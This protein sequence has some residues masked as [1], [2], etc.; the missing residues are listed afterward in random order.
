[1]LAGKTVLITGASSGIGAA[2][3]EKFA[4]AGARLLLLA[5]RRERL[6]ALA[7]ELHSRFSAS[8]HLLVCDVRDRH[9]VEDTLGSLPPAWADIDILVNNA[10]LARGLA[11]LHEGSYDDWEEMIDTNLKGLLAVT[12]AVLPRMVAR[13][14]GMIINIASIAGREVYP[15]GN[16]YCATK[17]AVRALSEALRIDLNGTNIRVV[18]IDPGLVETEFSLVRFR[19]DAERA[20]KVY[21]GLQPLTAHDVAEL[22]LFCAT[23][24]PHVVIADVLIVPTAQATTWL[25]HR[26]QG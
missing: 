12:R 21:E 11:P 17:H 7:H 23:R 20:R 26:Q 5:R 18:N 13:R 14:S 6:E 22:V 1:M 15:N 24:P 3:A 10:G 25:V 19:G 8:C 4:E 2:C 16:V 9:Q